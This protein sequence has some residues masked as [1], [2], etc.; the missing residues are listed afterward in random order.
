MV[1]A[2]D[3]LALFDEFKNTLTPSLQ[4]MVLEKWSPEKIRKHMAPY[5]QARMVMEALTGRGK[6]GYDSRKD[7]LDRNEGT[8]VQ[9]QETMHRYG[10]MD[11]DELKALAA[12]Q[13]REAEIEV[14][15]EVVSP[16]VRRRRTGGAEK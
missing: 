6:V 12:H 8:P 1:E 9:R 3:D 15:S 13:L 14:K 7:I 10:K 16:K 2:L 11:L 4:R 5:V